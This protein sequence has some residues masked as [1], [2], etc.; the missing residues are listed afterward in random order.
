[1]SIPQV[2]DN[3]I[4]KNEP[5][6]QPEDNV[7]FQRDMQKFDRLFAK[8]ERIEAQ[9]EGWKMQLYQRLCAAKLMQ[10]VKGRKR[11]NG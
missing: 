10:G 5:P 3:C 9:Q 1:M 8:I 11:K 7:N 6:W 2:V 4:Y